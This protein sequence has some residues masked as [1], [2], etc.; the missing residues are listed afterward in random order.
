LGI[1][2]SQ[3]ADRA[4]GLS[5][6]NALFTKT[7]STLA[8]RLGRIELPNPEGIPA[9]IPVGRPKETGMTHAVKEVELHRI[10]YRTGRFQHELAFT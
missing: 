9:C 7:L 2:S 5:E 8:G 6:I 4:E 1:S 3:N 10:Q